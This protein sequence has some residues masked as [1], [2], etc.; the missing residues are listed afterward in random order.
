M[1][2]LRS[3]RLEQF[4]F[5]LD[6]ETYTKSWKKIF[7]LIILI[8]FFVS[9]MLSIVKECKRITESRSLSLLLTLSLVLII[10]S[11]LAEAMQVIIG[12]NPFWSCILIHIILRFQKIVYQNWRLNLS[13]SSKSIFNIKNHTNLSDFFHLKLT[14]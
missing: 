4:K 5:K 13:K 11:T 12:T 6:L 14:V 1:R 9:R 2:F 7:L 3:N 10:A 8:S